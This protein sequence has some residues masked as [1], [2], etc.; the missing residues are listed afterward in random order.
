MDV[1]S[2]SR[3]PW[4]DSNAWRI[5]RAGQAGVFY[6]VK[7]DAAALAAA[8]AF[9]FGATAYIQSDSQGLEPFA[10]MLSFLRALPEQDLPVLANIGLIDDGSDATGELM[11]LLLRHNLLFRVVSQPDPQLDLTVKIGTEAFPK[12][13]LDDP[14]ALVQKIRGQLTDEKRLLRIYGSPVVL[15][16]LTGAGGRVRL[17]LLNYANRPVE[18]IRIRVLGA[19]AHAKLAIAGEPAAKLIDLSVNAGATEFTIAKMHHYAVVD[20]SK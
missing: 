2:A 13:S 3:L 7:G 6:D 16:R 20:L 10:A 5:L 18:G 4:L 9:T 17:Q 19:Y 12:S 15:G 14:A 11:N 8:E 1:A